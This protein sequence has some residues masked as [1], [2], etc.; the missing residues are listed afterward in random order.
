MLD[1]EK[2]DKEST[3]LIHSFSREQL[4]E[5]VESYHQEIALA[6]SEERIQKTAKQSP[7]KL[8]G[9]PQNAAKSQ[10]ISTKMTTS[11]K[12]ARHSKITI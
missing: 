2:I 9:S 3:E 5:F 11:A 10:S 12:S 8:N 4:L 6:K 7:V 1:L